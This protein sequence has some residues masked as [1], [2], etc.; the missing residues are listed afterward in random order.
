MEVRG[1][2]DRNANRVGIVHRGSARQS[3]KR[4]EQSRPA[5]KI[6]ELPSSPES[7]RMQPR[8]DFRTLMRRRLSFQMRMLRLSILTR[9]IYCDDP[10]KRASGGAGVR[11]WCWGGNE[12]LEALIVPERIEHWIEPE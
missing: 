2:Q 1:M 11:L 12:F 3:W 6:Q 8:H 4:A 5:N 10:R 9:G 7:I